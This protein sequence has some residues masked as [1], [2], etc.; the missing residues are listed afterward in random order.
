MT[1]WIRA[2]AAASLL[3]LAPVGAAMAQAFPSKPLKVVVGFAP[4]GNLDVTAR[5][6]AEA[7][8]KTLGQPIV[9]ENRP[10]AGGVIGN[11]AVAKSPPD[12][13]TL[14]ATTTA[15]TI[16]SPL[17]VPTSPYTAA[18]FSPVGVM[19][20]TPLLVE[21]PVA[22]PYADF[23][24]YLA[25]VR[26]KPGT[27]SVAHSG[28]GTS[29]HVALLLIQDALKVK[30]N[31]VPYKGSGPAL[32][33]TIGGQVDSI[34]DQLSSSL[35]QVKAGKLRPLAVGSRTRLADL[36]N[37]PTL[38]EEGMKG[39]EAVTASMLLAPAQTPPAVLKALNVALNKALADP[40]VAKKLHDLGAVLRPTS[41][42][43][44]ERFLKDE[45]AKLTA[46]AKT[47]VLKSD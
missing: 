15:V 31:I 40:A 8:S 36:P 10:G 46:L 3:V 26:A 6:L 11:D 9:V 12:G 4:G 27:V 30:F 38:E 35:P 1:Q 43:E 42:E 37:V 33:D 2:A 13:Y 29:N 16:V 28:N 24:S 21:V 5:I 20:L 41:V 45:E 17:M 19:Q 25:A 44:A 34:V 18:N 23:K 39:F 22:S 47:G 32:I 7:M 14:V